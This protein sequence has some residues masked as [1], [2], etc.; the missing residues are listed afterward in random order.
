MA[1]R[2]AVITN[3]PNSNRNAVLVSWSGLLNGDDGSPFEAA[4]FADRTVQITGTL[5]VG[6]TITIEG[7]NDG[8][9]WVALTDPQGNAV[10]KTALGIE[11]IE[12]APRYTR[13]HVTGGDVNT[14]L[15]VTLW[16]RRPR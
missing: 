5:G 15:V 9:N 12:E 13:P 10:T 16:C 6:G 11:T 7:S 8:T 2:T 1:T 14:S 3:Q 4:D